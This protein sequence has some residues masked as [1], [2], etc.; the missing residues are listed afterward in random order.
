MTDTPDA[1]SGNNPLYDLL[2]SVFQQADATAQFPLLALTQVLQ[3]V[4]QNLQAGVETLEDV[5]FVGTGTPD[6]LQQIAA[7]VGVTL[8]FPLRPEHRALVAD[9]IA[10]RRRKGTAAA[11][12]LLLR[13]ASNWY[14]LVLQADGSIPPSAWPLAGGGSVPAG[15]VTRVR[16]WVWRLPVHAMDAIPIFQ[17]SAG[18]GIVPTPW[19]KWYVRYKVNPLDLPEPIWNVASTALP[20][21]SPPVTALPVAVTTRLLAADLDRYRSDWPGAVAG[22]PADSLFYGP[23]R[24]LLFRWQ[25]TGKNQPWQDLP[26]GRVRAGTLAQKEFPPP[27]YVVFLSGPIVLSDVKSGT[28]NVTVL[29]DRTAAV[30]TVTI[31]SQPTMLQLA[32]ALQAALRAATPTTIGDVSTADLQATQ[33]VPVAPPPALALGQH[34]AVIPGNGI[35]A[36]IQFASQHHGDPD[37]L[38]LFAQEKGGSALALRTA[39]ITDALAARLCDPDQDPQALTFTDATDQNHLVPLPLASDKTSGWSITDVVAALQAV[40]VEEAAVLAVAGR[41]II[42]VFPGYDGSP[43]SQGVNSPEMGRLCWDLGLERAAILDPEAGSLVWPAGWAKP[44][45]ITASY[46]RAAVAAIGSGHDRAPVATDPDAVR[47]QVDATN[48]DQTLRRWADADPAI[49]S[50]VFTLSDRAKFRPAMDSTIPP[51]IFFASSKVSQTLALQARA[52]RVPLIAPSL[53]DGSPGATPLIIGG[54]AAHTGTLQFDGLLIHGGLAIAT[55]LNGSSLKVMLTDTTLY[56]E[57]M[58]SSLAEQYVDSTPPHH[59]YPRNTLDFSAE[60]CILGA[61]DGSNMQGT[62]SLADCIV[63]RLP[64]PGLSEGD[65]AAAMATRGTGIATLPRHVDLFT[66]DAAVA[67]NVFQVQVRRSTILGHMTL[68][69]TSSI[70]AKDVLF[71]GSLTVAGS[72]KLDHCYVADLQWRLPHLAGRLEGDPPEAATMVRCQRCLGV[73]AVR[74]WRCHVRALTLDPERLRSCTCGF[75]ATEVVSCGNSSS[76]ERGDNPLKGAG[77]LWQLAGPP[78]FYPDNRY[79]N[80]NFARLTDDNLAW[81][82]SGASD[83]GE[84]GA[85]NCARMADRSRQF[86]GA[87]SSALPLGVEADITFLS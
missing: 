19:A 63:S 80:A 83:G 39:P 16:L 45:N 24:G 65:A 71:A 23:D 76:D 11:L 12:P 75:G 31:P 43:F 73:Q 18:N 4:E 5:W 36:S 57:G 78:I 84:I 20:A 59:T 74:L 25:P 62:L 32:A 26:P 72:F 44:D 85:F 52:R 54:L 67:G 6:I 81:L 47:H 61:I 34:L 79:P 51:V 28:N 50:A 9:A 64:E 35:I 37:D 10:V 49:K 1:S 82:L 46:G 53:A 41:V 22:A 8:P 56:A 33:V 30:L 13:G 87:L 21:A 40:L 77:R 66:T 55:V 48:F 60:R 38:R 2:P 42:I 58:A 68:Y 70:D 7:L 69:G 29:M 3:Q 17:L 15:Q 86:S 27:D 14:A